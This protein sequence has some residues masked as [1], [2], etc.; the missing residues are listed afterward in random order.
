MPEHQS[1]NKRVTGHCSDDTEVQW[2]VLRQVDFTTLPLTCV[3]LISALWTWNQAL[4]QGTSVWA[5]CKEQ[6]A[7]LPMQW[8]T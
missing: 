1:G 2:C 7:Q 3:R 6:L 5:R 4:G 8:S